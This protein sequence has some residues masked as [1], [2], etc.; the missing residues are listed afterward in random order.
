VGASD[1]GVVDALAVLGAGQVAVVGRLPWSSNGTFLVTCALEDTEL[2]AVYK[3]QRGERALWDF[4]DGLFRREAA[5][6]VVSEALGWGLVPET[7]VRVDAPYGPGSMQRFVDADFAE[8]YFTLV[9]DP[10]THAQLRAVCALDVVINNADRKSGHCLVD[11]GGRIWAIDNGLSFHVEP[12]LRTVIWEFAGEELDRSQCE[13]L[14]ALARTP[15][16]VLCELVSPV[17][18][19]AMATRAGRLAR[20]G[21]L[22]HPDPTRHHYPWPLV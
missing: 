9:E 13:A 4:P 18:V 15:P 5:A 6:F 22:P 14:A 19:E 16:D 7:I 21:R 2:G 12:K 11:G 3:P 17:E 1:H 10:A 8:H 20:S